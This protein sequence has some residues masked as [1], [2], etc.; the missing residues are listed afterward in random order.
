MTRG[1]EVLL[2][3]TY[4][5]VRGLQ[6]DLVILNEEPGSYE[7]PLQ[8]KLAKL[9]QSHSLLTGID[10]PG[11]IFL[12]AADQLPPEDLTL[13]LAS[14]HAALVATRGSL[15]QQM[16]RPPRRVELP[17]DL[18]SRRSREEPALPPS[19][20]HL[21]ARRQRRTRAANYLED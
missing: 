7:Q 13:L 6:V 19:S 8:N 20:P 14:A 1:R 10:R 11:G 15:A 9:I 12:R 21:P 4:W 16:S 2:A 3:H 18:E 5:R 17:S